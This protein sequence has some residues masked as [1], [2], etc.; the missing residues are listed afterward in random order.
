MQQINGK[1]MPSTKAQ[2]AAWTKIRDKALLFAVELSPSYRT[3]Q[4]KS[5]VGKQGEIIGG[6]K[7]WIPNAKRHK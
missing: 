3:Q 2:K 1:R 7:T 4:E 6:G 5:Q